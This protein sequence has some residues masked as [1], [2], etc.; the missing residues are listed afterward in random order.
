[1]RVLTDLGERQAIKIIERVLAAGGSRPFL[2]DDCAALD[3]GP[4]YLLITTD[5][6]AR[7]THI[8][9]IMTPYQV[10]WTLT[11]VNLSDIAA[12]GGEPHGLVLSYGLPPSTTEAF[13]KEMTKGAMTCAK[14]NGTRI[15]GGDTKE[16]TD[17]TLCGT[18]V[19]LVK[20]SEFMP[21]KG[22]R[23]GDIIAVTGTLGKAGAG[24]HAIHLKDTKKGVTRSFLEPTPRLREGRLLAR[25]HCITASMDLSDGLSS[26][27]YQLRDL[28]HVG[29]TI[30]TKRLPASSELQT[31]LKRHP[32]LDTEQILLHFGGDYELLVT[33]PPAQFPRISKMMQHQ[34][35]R[36][37]R[38]GTVTKNKKI[39]TNDGAKTQPLPNNGYEHFSPHHGKIVPEPSL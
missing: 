35:C 8:P 37:T 25:T 19:G 36:L 10:G 2:G 5:L 39:I 31:L 6:I 28:N 4:Q 16:A 1:V 34:K 24:Y 15:V 17:I 7:K 32:D 29:F 11:A 18:A 9:S 3:L 27:L 14:R 12:K 13:L 20:K 26:S 38:I 30:E 33:L 23:P 21:R 22:A